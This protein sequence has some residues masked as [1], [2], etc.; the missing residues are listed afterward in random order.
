MQWFCS[1]WPQGT[2]RVPEEVEATYW[3]WLSC[4]VVSTVGWHQEIY[5]T[6]Y[7]CHCLQVEEL[8]VMTLILHGIY[9]KWG[10]EFCVCFNFPV[11]IFLLQNSVKD[12]T[13]RGS[14]ALASRH[15]EL[16]NEHRQIVGDADTEIDAYRSV[17][18]MAVRKSVC[19]LGGP[20]WNVGTVV[21]FYFLDYIFQLY[22]M[23]S[24]HVPVQIWGR[25]IHVLLQRLSVLTQ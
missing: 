6:N 13:A 9:D 8:I 2:E 16:S 12:R 5:W 22:L 10:L 14:N 7:N 20:R 19:M 24:N 15:R 1:V 18:G 11:F 21:H 3:W 17:A 4:S 23:Q 25:A